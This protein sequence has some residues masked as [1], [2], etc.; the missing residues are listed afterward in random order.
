MLWPTFVGLLAVLPGLFIASSLPNRVQTYQIIQKP[1]II[2][3]RAVYLT[4]YTAG[5]P[6][7][8]GE[9]IQLV[10][11]TELNAVVIDI[12]DASGKVFYDSQ[13]PLARQTGAIELRIPNV[14]EIVAELHRHDIYAIARMVVFQDPQLASSVPDVALASS[15]GGLWRD[16]KGLAWVDPTKREVWEYNL[17][18]AKEVAALGFDEINFDYIRFPSDGDIKKIVFDNIPDGYEKYDVMREFFQYLDAELSV[19]PVRTSAD[20]FGMTLW[21]SDGLN[22]GQRIEDAAPYFDYIMP[23]VY[24]SHY[25]PGFEKF[26]NPAEHP[27]EIIYRSLIRYSELAKNGRARLSPWLQDFDL[28]AVYTPA[29]I[30]LQKQASYDSGGYGWALWNARNVYTEGGLESEN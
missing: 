4:A 13:I 26:A 7:R 6:V 22:I 27:Y 15:G 18:L 2:E 12:K 29:M 8:R 16:W 21:R 5:N 28:G 30:G 24:P 14:K 10:D 23:M 17:A 25:P 9:L 19:Q 1:P 3:R 20:L 11:T